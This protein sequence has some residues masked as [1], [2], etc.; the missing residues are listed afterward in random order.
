LVFGATKGRGEGETHKGRNQKDNS[1]AGAE[2]PIFSGSTGGR[3]IRWAGVFFFSS[4]S[5]S[6]R[7]G[8]GYGAG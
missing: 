6:N 4:Q 3:A 8:L 7:H 2:G 1:K 5:F